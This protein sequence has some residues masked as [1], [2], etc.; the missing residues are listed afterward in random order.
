MRDDHRDT[1]Y[2]IAWRLSG[3]FYDLLFPVEGFGHH[4]LPNTGGFIIAS[5]HLSYLDP[6]AIGV[7]IDRD[8]AYFARKSLFKPPFDRL[9]KR[10][11]AIP[12]D[13]DSGSDLAAMKG[14][15]SC[16]RQGLPLVLFPEGTRSA[17]GRLLPG[18]RGIGLL[19]AKA[20]VPVVPCRIFGTLEAW[21]RNRR[22]RPGTGIAVCFGPP[23]SAETITT[24]VREHGKQRPAQMIMEAIAGI[25][26]PTPA[27]PV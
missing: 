1:F 26:P 25:E 3:C 17:D 19:A 11:H 7:S 4:H 10:V 8:M 24:G 13:R 14:A 18:K 5:N 16:L 9:L 21:G 15:L 22:P 23:I 12:V 27:Y 6:P 2:R 20:R